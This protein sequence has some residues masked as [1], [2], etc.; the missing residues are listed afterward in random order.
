[1]RR[2]ISIQPSAYRKA[3]LVCILCAAFCTPLL[4]QEA[5]YVYRNDGDFNGFFYDEVKEMRYSKLALDGTESDQYVTYEIELED[6]V[7]RIPL[8]AIDSIGFQQPEIKLNPKVKFIEKD[9][10]SPYIA[11]QFILGSGIA[12]QTYR[13]RNLPAELIP[14]VGDVLI[15]LPTDSRAEEEYYVSDFNGSFSCKVESVQTYD[16][17]DAGGPFKA[18]DVVGSFV[19]NISDVFVQYITVEQIGVDKQGNIHRRMAGCTPEGF[20][21]YAPA[22]SGEGEVSL[23]DFTSTLT[24]TWNPNEN[25][26][27]DLA[28]ELNLK[29]KLRAAYNISWSR[30]MTTISQDFITQVKPSFGLS[31]SR[32]FEFDSGELMPVG[33]I[34]FPAVC[35]VF[36]IHPVPSLFFRGEGKAEAKLNMPAVKMG[37]GMHY[38]IDTDSFFPISCGLHLAEDEEGAEISDEM[39]DLSGELTLNG[40]IQAGIKFSGDISTA[41]WMKKILKSSIGTYLYVGPKVGGQLTLGQADSEGTGSVYNNMVSSYLHVAMPSLDLEAKA[42][43]SAFSQEEKEK[44]FFDKNWSFFADTVHLAPSFKTPV[45][46]LDEENMLVTIPSEQYACLGYQRVAARVRYSDI[47]NPYIAY[48]S[49]D[50]VYTRKKESFEYTIPLSSMRATKYNVYPLVYTWLPDPLQATISTKV[51]IP[52]TIQLSDDSLTFGATTNLE[53]SIEITT[54]A[55]DKNKFWLSGGSNISVQK[56]AVDSV[57]GQYRM[58]LTMS[59]NSGLFDRRISCKVVAD[60]EI[61]SS[62]SNLRKEVP[63]GI[64]QKA[65]DLP[66]FKFSLIVRSDNCSDMWFGYSDIHPV[67]ATRV[68]DNKIHVEGHDVDGNYEYTVN[69]DLIR[70]GETNEYSVS[71]TVTQKYEEESSYAD[72]NTGRFVN[73]KE[74]TNWSA[75]IAPTEDSR[76]TVT[77]ATYDLLRVDTDTNETLK[78]DHCEDA[79]FDIYIVDAQVQLP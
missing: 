78:T 54:N 3:I 41:T 55:V 59:P 46:K 4:A 67:T 34:V 13:F 20:P 74:T 22:A 17:E 77:Q 26:N 72:I 33:E 36:A 19:E 30:F 51:Y 6:T 25:I 21:R 10:Y 40:Y 8:S 53:Q 60:C 27:V 14:N 9:G 18:C 29:V 23:I 58:T 43:V 69:V 45:V 50:I 37:L 76:G 70:R 73:Y 38:I 24:R 7:Y 42:T 12:K 61:S 28:A 75:T 68:G 47:S 57:A 11:P 62:G 1:M 5:F 65:N 66:G 49:S 2:A 79:N 35:P 15:G 71:G 32:D 63:L 56:E 64:Y 16:N 52:P 39:L 44:K 48:E 31:Y